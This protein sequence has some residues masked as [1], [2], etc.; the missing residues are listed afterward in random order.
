MLFFFIFPDHDAVLFF[1]LITCVYTSQ[2]SLGQD[3]ISWGVLLLFMGFH[4]LLVFLSSLSL[5]N[6]WQWLLESITRS[7]KISKNFSRRRY[8]LVSF[9]YFAL[10]SVGIYLPS[11]Y[12]FCWSL[13]CLFNIL[14]AIA[15]N[16]I[17]QLRNS[18]L[19]L[20][21]YEYI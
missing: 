15:Y 17:F 19:S 8:H 14:V 3:N 20:L 4:L 9:Y 7:Y 12:L 21:F 18:C 13:F 1:F 10:S 2:V 5:G 16:D 11:F 6:S